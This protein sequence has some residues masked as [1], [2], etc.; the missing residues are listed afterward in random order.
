MTESEKKIKKYNSERITGEEYPYIVK[1]TSNMPGSSQAQVMDDKCK[2][3]FHFSEHCY[4]CNKFKHIYEEIAG[5]RK[6]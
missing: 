5:E 3:I 4:S 2:V 1:G 6:R